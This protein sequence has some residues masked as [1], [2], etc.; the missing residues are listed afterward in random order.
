MPGSKQ[1]LIELC[2]VGDLEGLLSDFW[3]AHKG[4]TPEQGG[5]VICVAEARVRLPYGVDKLFSLEIGDIR[6]QVQSMEHFGR[7]WDTL[8]PQNWLSFFGSVVGGS[9]WSRGAPAVTAKT[10][11]AEDMSEQLNELLQQSIYAFTKRWGTLINDAQS[12]KAGV[13]PIANVEAELDGMLKGAF[14][15][16]PDVVAKLKEAIRLNAES[17]GQVGEKRF[18]PGRRYKAFVRVVGAPAVK[19]SCSLS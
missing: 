7:I 19:L 5:Y 10:L 17:E 15:N 3:V 13:K 2:G 1:R 16:Q 4:S 12:R 14:N 6:S 11:T 9:L 8:S 18:R